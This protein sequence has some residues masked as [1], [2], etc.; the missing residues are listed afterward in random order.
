[1][2]FPNLVD[3]LAPSPDSNPGTFS[4]AKTYTFRIG[5]QRRRLDA[6][7]LQLSVTNDASTAANADGVSGL[8]KEVRVI[9]NDVL[10][11]RN[12]VKCPGSALIA[13]VRNNLGRLDRY[14]QSAMGA[15]S[16]GTLTASATMLCHFWI[17]LRALFIQEPYANLTSLPLSSSWIK[18][19]VIVEVDLRAASEVY[20]AGA[21]TA[22]AIGAVALYRDVPDNIPYIPSELITDPI[23]FGA[24]ARQEYQ[25]GQ[26]GFLTQALIQGYVSATYANTATRVQLL[27]AAGILSFEYGRTVLRRGPE[28]LLRAIND[29]SQNVVGAEGNGLITGNQMERRTPIGEVMFDFVTD[30]PE[31]DA[32]SIFSILN[33]SKDAL[34]GDVAR[35]VWSDWANTGYQGRITYHKLLPR[36]A[37][38]FNLL[39]KGGA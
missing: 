17:P 11:K 28:S 5:Q 12:V 15:G 33:L 30:F 16:A 35:I 38:D 27:S 29:Y 8:V 14:T 10:G 25:F 34:G 4:A 24:A 23:S 26:S 18:E 32:F 22:S 9:A 19:D 1:M 36:S 6:I 31:T 39:T 2:R 13:Y 20:S 37:E 3:T 7:L 21:P